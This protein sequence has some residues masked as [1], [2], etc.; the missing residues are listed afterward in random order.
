[1]RRFVVAIFAILLLML[2]TLALPT[3]EDMTLSVDVLVVTAA[4]L[5]NVMSYELMPIQATQSTRDSE[6]A[7]GTNGYEAALFVTDPG[8]R[9]PRPITRGFNILKMPTLRGTSRK[10]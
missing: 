7:T 6:T 10:V 8:A 9:M 5:Q 1:M 2:T 3:G 4:P